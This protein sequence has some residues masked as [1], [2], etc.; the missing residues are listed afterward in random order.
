MRS[1]E[2]RN[3]SEVHSWG[4]LCF[5]GVPDHSWWMG[6]CIKKDAWL[7][8]NVGTSLT[9]WWKVTSRWIYYPS[10]RKTHLLIKVFPKPKALKVYIHQPWIHTPA[11]NL[12]FPS[13]DWA[14]MLQFLHNHVSWGKP[15]IKVS[16]GFRHC[17]KMQN[18]AYLL[19]QHSGL[20][21]FLYLFLHS[22]IFKCF[23]KKKN[24]KAKC[25]RKTIKLHLGSLEMLVWVTSACSGGTQRQTI[26]III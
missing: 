9:L 6:G 24:Q 17:E 12:L 7:N 23:Q 14:L 8:K 10:H 13:S 21:C 26:F 11:H 25:V 20:K 22:S 5:W 4:G 3:R 19:H 18:A 15:F 1:R 2:F 16:E